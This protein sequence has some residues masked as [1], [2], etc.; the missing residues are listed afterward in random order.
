MPDG[1][2]VQ[3]MQMTLE[4][5]NVKLGEVVGDVTGAFVSNKMAHAG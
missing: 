4:E 3:H 5:M 2:H 1:Q